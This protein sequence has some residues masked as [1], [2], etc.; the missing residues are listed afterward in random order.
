MRVLYR[1]HK[2]PPPAPFLN[3]IK[4][5]ND[6]QSHFLKVHFSMIFPSRP[7]STK[8]SPFLRSPHQNPVCTS[9]VPRTWHMPRPSHYS[10]FYHKNDILWGV[11]SIN[12]SLYSL[13]HSPV[14]SSLLVPNIFLSTL[15]SKTLSLRSFLH[16]REQFPN[17]HKTTGKII[18]L[19]YSLYFWIATWKSKDSVL[20]G[21]KHSLTSICS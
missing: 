11:H 13:L 2:S 5:A 15:F 19:F 3:H 12:S 8:W 4:P 18:I 20:N 6:S 17:P 21:S 9:P 16:V 7:R 14:T 1:I 10:W